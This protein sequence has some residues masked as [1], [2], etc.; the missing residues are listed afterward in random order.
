LNF[1]G[2]KDFILLVIH[3]FTLF[4]HDLEKQLSQTKIKNFENKIGSVKEVS[5]PSQNSIIFR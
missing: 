5:Q 1:H 2:Y 3:P 4:D